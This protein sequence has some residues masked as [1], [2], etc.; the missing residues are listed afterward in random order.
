MN[1]VSESQRD[2]HAAAGAAAASRIV[3]RRPCATRWRPIASPGL[4]AP[5][6]DHL[7]ML[8]HGRHDA[9]NTDGPHPGLHL[10]RAGG[11]LFPLV[12]ILDELA[13]R[14]HAVALRTLAS[15]VPLMRERGFDASP[16]APA[17][18]AIP[19]DDFQGR[20][21]NARIKRAMGAFGRRAEHDLDDLREAIDARAP[22]RCSSTA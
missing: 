2:R 7:V 17:I 11:H 5:D 6:H 4:A 13:R 8:V 16:I 15:E 9:G 14:G 20:T 21:P 19:L 3:N 18:E 12:P 1:S 22:T 10:P